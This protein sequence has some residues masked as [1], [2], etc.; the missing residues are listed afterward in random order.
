MDKQDFF[1]TVKDNYYK[2]QEITFTELYEMYKCIA[3]I[4]GTLRT[5]IEKS[6]DN[7]KIIFVDDDSD[8]STVSM[9]LYL[10][11]KNIIEAVEHGLSIFTPANKDLILFYGSLIGKKIRYM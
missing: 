6:N 9:T 5:E 1:N 4:F 8:I 7:T 3:P 10:N 11:K 2:N